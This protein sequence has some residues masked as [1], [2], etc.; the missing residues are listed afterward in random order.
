[1]ILPM[2]GK[3]CRV[4]FF[5]ILAYVTLDLSLPE[6]PGAFVFEPA[7]SAESTQIRARAAAEMVA[8]SAQARDRGSVLSQPPL[9]PKALFAPTRSAE[10]HVQP[11]VSWRPRAPYDSAPPS[12]DPH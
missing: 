7:D 10:R 4:A 1:M 9:E 3:R 5:A 6:M 12:V 2:S 8:L 11:V